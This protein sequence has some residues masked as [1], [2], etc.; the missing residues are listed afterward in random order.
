MILE[1]ETAMG[2]ARQTVRTYKRR[3]QRSRKRKK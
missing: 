2:K 3:A 1:E